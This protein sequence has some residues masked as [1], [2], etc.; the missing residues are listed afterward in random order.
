V[1]TRFV[2]T[3]EFYFEH[4]GFRPAVVEQDHMVLTGPQGARLGV[5]RAGNPTQPAA[6]QH[7]TRGTGLCLSR[8]RTGR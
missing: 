7:G 6:L 3:C 8:S 4:F 1:T 5:M 2:A